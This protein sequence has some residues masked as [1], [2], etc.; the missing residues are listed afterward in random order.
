MFFEII[1][2]EG[3]AHQSYLVGGNG[4]AAV[5][6]PR[7]DCGVYL[8][9][10]AAH[11]AAI[12]HLFETHRNEDYVT[13]S[14]ELARRT[15]AVIHHGAALPFAFGTPAHHGDRFRAGPLEIVA[16]ETPG[17]TDESLSFALYEPSVPGR[18]VMVFT[19]DALFAGSVG[20][21]DLAGDDPAAN[22]RRLYDSLNGVLLPLGDG[23][24]VCPAHGAGSVC[25]PSISDLPFTTIGIERASNPYL[26][27]DREAFVA[28]KAGEEGY[29][30]PYF[31]VMEQLNLAG[32]P[33]PPDLCALRPLAPADLEG[34]QVVDIRSPTGFAA[35]HIPGS[36]NIWRDGLPLFI[37]W[38]LDYEQP[39]ALVDDFNQEIH[40]AAAHFVRLGF[41]NIA[42]YLGG[43]YA[44]WLRGARPVG[45]IETLTVQDLHARL[46]KMLVL[47]VRDITNREERGAI[48]GSMHI[49]A[50]E[51]AARI[52]EVPID[53][54]IAVHCDVGFKGSL[55]ASLLTARGAS[56]VGNVL[57][58]FAAWTA[59]GLPV[60]KA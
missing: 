55:A 2:S 3:L 9:R 56:R 45:R 33:A 36:I 53:R 31:T 24:I 39:I 34:M 8:E 52:D 38:T 12:T 13:G 16:L 59:A 14:V 46:D 48:P 57:G 5:I 25:G 29:H 60:E 28:R 15:G 47:D 20:R 4:E 7:R 44:S 30:A 1:R 41:D 10:A 27:L 35:G 11:G 58:G 49:Y 37:G 6:D 18:P 50:G 32:P 43:G 21:V 40:D 42:G 23:T 51:L 26:K 22:A 19:G 54:P 17:H